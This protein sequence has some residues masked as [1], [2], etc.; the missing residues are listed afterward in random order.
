MANE[1][2]RTLYELTTQLS[3][4]EIHIDDYHNTV[5]ELLKRNASN[6]QVS[7]SYFNFK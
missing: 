5:L 6:G 1:C 2:E 4:N 7:V 3:K